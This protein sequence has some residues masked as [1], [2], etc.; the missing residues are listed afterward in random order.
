MRVAQTKNALK[1]ELDYLC[2]FKPERQ[3]QEREIVQRDRNDINVAQQWYREDLVR[4]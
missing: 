2:T 4:K 1:A 3:N